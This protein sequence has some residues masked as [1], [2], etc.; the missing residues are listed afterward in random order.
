MKLYELAN[1]YL[2]LQEMLDDEEA[3]MEELKDTLDAINDDLV[4]K[5]D[6]ICRLRKK[7]DAYVTT[8]KTEAK[9]LTAMAKMAESRSQWLKSYLDDTLKRLEIKSM[10]TE[11]FKLSYRKSESVNIT[12][13]PEFIP[14]EYVKVTYTPDKVGL[15]KAIKDGATFNGVEL[16]QGLNLQIR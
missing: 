15:K 1:N 14:P 5:V 8:Y 12:V 9:R 13:S 2:A 3:T 4:I 16:V 10:D 6:N 11:L 7:L